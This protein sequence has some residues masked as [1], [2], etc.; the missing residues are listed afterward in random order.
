M[1]TEHRAPKPDQRRYRVALHAL[2]RT[3]ASVAREAGVSERYVYQALQGRCPLS[4]RMGAA[5]RQAVGEEGWRYA[6]GLS[7]VLPCP[8]AAGKEAAR[9]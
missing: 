1:S 7:D 2:G 4:P 6:C 9:P 5:L 3:V 8:A